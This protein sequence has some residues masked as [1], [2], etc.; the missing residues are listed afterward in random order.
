MFHLIQILK[1]YPLHCFKIMVY[2]TSYYAYTGTII[3]LLYWLM[4]INVL[5]IY[6]YCWQ[7]LFSQQV[8]QFAT[9]EYTQYV[10]D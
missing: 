8:L 7:V 6:F 5:H 10:Y 3:Q 2:S 9:Q 1:D 4:L